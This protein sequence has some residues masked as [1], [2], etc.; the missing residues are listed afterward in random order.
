M[1][2]LTSSLQSALDILTLHEFSPLDLPLDLKDSLWDRLE[3][4]YKLTLGQF[5]ALRNFVKSRDV[6]AAAATT[7]TTCMLNPSSAS[8]PPAASA[9]NKRTRSRKTPRQFKECEETVTSV[10]QAARSVVVV[11]GKLYV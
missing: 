11:K 10:S 2:S 9:N 8:P 1:S 4:D 7:T 6:A 5:S 3:K